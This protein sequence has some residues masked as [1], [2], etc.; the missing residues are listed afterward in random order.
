[1]AVI[2]FA[3]AKGGAGKT[4]ATLARTEGKAT[5]GRPGRVT[6]ATKVQSP[7]KWTAETP[8]LYTL[9]VSLLDAGGRIIEV[10][11]F[12]IGFREVEIKDGQLLV[13][14]RHVLIRG[15]N[16]HEHDPDRGHAITVASME[17]DAQ[18][19]KQMKSLQT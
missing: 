4:V 7:R 17:R 18:L 16:R 11:P 1:M 19:M 6:L 8:N 12:E 9:L 14:G 3:N 5:V 2:T 10:L 13:N 15:V